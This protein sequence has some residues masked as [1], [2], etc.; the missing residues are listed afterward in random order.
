MGDHLGACAKMGLPRTNPHML[1]IHRL[2]HAVTHGMGF[3]LILAPL[4][5]LVPVS[6]VCAAPP[7]CNR[8][9][10]APELPHKK[11]R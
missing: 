6:L 11:G 7:R 5:L 4:L 3:L 10:C 8:C 1:E 9:T 2:L